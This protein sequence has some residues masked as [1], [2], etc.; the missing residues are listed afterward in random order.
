MSHRIHTSWSENGGDFS[1]DV[2][3]RINTNDPALHLR[4]DATSRRRSSAPA[5]IVSR[6][7]P[8]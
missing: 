3:S 2:G 5:A 4:N 1:V 7:E 6:V 8:S